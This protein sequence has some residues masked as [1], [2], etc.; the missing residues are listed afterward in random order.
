MS[1]A[2]ML[3][4]RI[5]LSPYLHTTYPILVNWLWGPGSVGADYLATG[6]YIALQQHYIIHWNMLEFQA[7]TC[8]GDA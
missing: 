6:P 5:D 3:S 7:L 1:D 4:L 8:L 2:L